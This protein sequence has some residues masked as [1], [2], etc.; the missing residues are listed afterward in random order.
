[1]QK[2]TAELSEALEQQTATSEVF[3]VIS[4][5]P[6]ELEAVFNAILENATRIC[7]AN[8]AICS[9]T[10]AAHFEPWHT[11]GF[12]RLPIAMGIIRKAR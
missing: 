9:D 5:S 4:S 2:R 8:S 7:G 11:F 6:G 12:C 10:T 1:M 3:Q